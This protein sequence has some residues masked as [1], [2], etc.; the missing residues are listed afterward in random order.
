M[1]Y[2]P[3]L[4][5]LSRCSDSPALA[6]YFELFWVVSCVLPVC[7]HSF[8]LRGFLSGATIF[9]LFQTRLYTCLDSVP[10]S[11]ISPS[12]PSFC[13]WRRLLETRFGQGCAHY[14]WGVDLLFPKA[15]WLLPLPPAAKGLPQLVWLEAWNT[16]GGV[17]AEHSEW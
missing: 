8:L 7:H 3:T 10:E 11:A 6:R 5:C 15:V 12:S 14:C 17:W 2:N 9:Q 16:R 1:V 13:C 4:S